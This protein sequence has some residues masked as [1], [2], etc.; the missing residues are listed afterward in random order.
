M[1]CTINYCK[2]YSLHMPIYIN[3]QDMH[4]Q[5]DFYH[6][7]QPLHATLSLSAIPAFYW[8]LWNQ[9]LYVLY[10]GLFSTSMCYYK[11]NF[12]CNYNYEG[13]VYN[14][15]AHHRYLKSTQLITLC[16]HAQQGQAIGRVRIYI[17][18]HKCTYVYYMYI[19]MWSKVTAVCTLVLKKLH[20]IW[21]A[22][23]SLHLHAA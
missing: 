1:K 4:F 16:M 19:I 3:T 10:K 11:S 22:G 23:V 2:W 17:Y 18:I 8:L 6:K 7:L 21:S 13:Y 12:Y 14:W 20:Q 15:Q 5:C 9:V